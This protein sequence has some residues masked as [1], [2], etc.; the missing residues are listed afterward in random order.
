MLGVVK[1]F[2]GTGNS[3]PTTAV[4]ATAAALAKVGGNVI[5]PA[6]ESFRNLLFESDA[7]DMESAEHETVDS[8]SASARLLLLLWMPPQEDEDGPVASEC[9]GDRGEIFIL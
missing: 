2:R 6:K 7:V 3:Y 8:A 5:S 4:A 1:S 9:N